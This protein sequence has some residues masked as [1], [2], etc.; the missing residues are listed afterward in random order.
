MRAAP[1]F[2]IG[3]LSLA[4]MSPGPASA[5]W[6]PY[7]RPVCT[8][9]SSQT[10]SAIATDGADGA[11]I[12]WQ[13]ARFPRV[14][15]FAQHVLASGEVDGAWP[16]D[17]RALLNDPFA[18]QNADAGQFNPEIAPDGAGGAIVTWQDLRSP[19]TETDIFAQHILATGVVDPA[20][21]DNGTALCTATGVQNTHVMIPDGAGGAIVT[22][23]DSRVGATEFDI[24]AEHVLASGLVDP[25]W[26][27]N[28]VA[29]CNLAGAQGFP[30]IVADGAG[31]AIVTWHDARVAA[32]IGFDIYAQ[33]VLNSGIVDP[34]WPVNG[35]AICVFHGDQGR[36]TIA[37]D[38][39][40]G[41]IIAWSDSRIDATSHIFAQHVF[42]SGA[43]DPVW[44]LNG[45]AISGAA[46]LE[47]RARAVPD[48][49]GGAIVTWQGFETQLNI[50]AQHVKAD[51]VVD[52]IWPAA[53]KAL[54]NAGRQ[55]SIQ[56]VAPDGAGGAIVAWV[57]SVDVVAQH[58]LATGAFDALYPATGRSIV[59]LPNK[60]GD[61]AIVATSGAGA[62]VSWTDGRNGLSPDIYALQVKEAGTGPTGVNT[63]AAAG[64]VVNVLPNPFSGSTRISFNSSGDGPVEVRIF[65]VLGRPVRSFAAPRGGTSQDVQ[66]DGRTGGGEAVP[67]GVY[68]CRVSTP[69]GQGV[70]RIVLVR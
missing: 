28:G 39:A 49:A 22:W 4:W 65:D 1:L 36:P 56:E 17:G 55:Q 2:L 8:A 3:S 15:M 30:A 41:A 35:R 37:S 12:A 20:W 32:S 5:A 25:L 21:P 38:G 62:I 45:R 44:P 52:P 51:G 16:H 64:V 60:Q 57:D 53:G 67:S 58:V 34:A 54:S 6:P 40:H 48:G 9:S 11:I 29:V 69:V 10:H 70:R 68:F 42:A 14:N 59:N 46:F 66:W 7:G 33:H 19:V 26:P 13:D 18:M 24:F 23:V 31:G 43:I 50:F 61:I 63:P 47:T 27:V